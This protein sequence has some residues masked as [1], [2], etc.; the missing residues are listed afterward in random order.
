[1]KT[2]PE[3]YAAANIRFDFSQSY[4]KELMDF[5]RAELAAI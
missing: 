5:V 3:T 4:I 1:L 2:I